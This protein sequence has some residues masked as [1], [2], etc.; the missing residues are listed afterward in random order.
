MSKIS[1][2][3]CVYNREDF[4]KRCLDS[5]KSQD[6]E[7]YEIVVVDDG[8]SDRTGEILKSYMI[9]PKFKICFNR[10]N[11]GLMASRNIGVEESNSDIVA[12]TDSDCIVDKNWLD[13]L[14]KPFDSDM[15]IVITGGS[16]SDGESEGY[17]SLVSRGIYNLK[18]GSGYVKRIIGCN[19]AIK[20]TFLENNRFDETLKYG[21]DETDLCRRASNSG[22]KVYFTEDAKITHFHRTTLKGLLEQRFKIGSGNAYFRIKHRTFPLVS[23]KT[24]ILIFI[25]FSAI[26]KLNPLT[27]ILGSISFIA[28]ILYDDIKKSSK[29]LL[30]TVFSLPGRIIMIVAECIG[31]IYGFFRFLKVL[32]KR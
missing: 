6:F 30:E 20:K 28:A 23:L 8:S 29:T 12:F 27:Y 15:D 5:I 16:I 3:I 18:K 21:A 32:F 11:K 17:W 7:N 22:L 2:I 13:Q 14:I 10:E 9:N 4:I 26:F 31:Y 25:L 1:V 24:L 19:M